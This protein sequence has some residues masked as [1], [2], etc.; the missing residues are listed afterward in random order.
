M[1]IKS[2][3]ATAVAAIGLGL[4][5]AVPLAAT[6]HG[7]GL[8]PHEKSTVAPNGMSVTVGHTDNWFHNVAPLNNMPTNRE[9]YLTNT[10]Y[11]TVEGGTGKIRT[12][13]FVGCAVDLDVSFSVDAHIGIDADVSVGVGVGST[14]VT[15]YADAGITPSIGGGIGFDLSITP[16]NITDI[17]L[18]EKELPSG[19]TGYIVNRDYR[20]KVEGCGG[21]LTVQ[22]YTVIEASSPEADVA[23]WVMG[24]PVIL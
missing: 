5:L 17:Q 19:G 4:G 12:G 20:L 14:G 22:A 13:W 11:G 7:G 2:A 9:V 1:N 16:G 3:L 18:G 8:A 10:S 23:D 6:A 21:P 15:P 24:D